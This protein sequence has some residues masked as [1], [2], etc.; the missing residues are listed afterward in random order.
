MDRD[1]MKK[2]LEF[3]KDKQQRIGEIVMNLSVIT[4]Q[5]NLVEIQ[6][7]VGNKVFEEKQ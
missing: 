2:T 7:F 6:E 4:T 5:R 3:E 1:E